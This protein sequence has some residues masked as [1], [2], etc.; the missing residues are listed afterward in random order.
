MAEPTSAVF[1]LTVTALQTWS[2]FEAMIKAVRNS[3]DD[4][5]HWTMMSTLI[6]NSCLLMKEKLER[7][8]IATLSPAQ[9]DFLESIEEFLRLFQADLS[10]LEMPDTDVFHGG[11]STF[12]D[13]AIAA[14]RLQLDQ[15][16]HLIKRLDRNIQM[17]Q[18]STSCLSLFEP[19][20]V[21]RVRD[22][23]NDLGTA[24]PGRSTDDDELKKWRQTTQNLLADTA[25]KYFCENPSPSD[26]QN[27]G[28]LPPSTH[29]KGSIRG[30]QYKFESAQNWAT[31]FFEADMPI[32]ALPYQ[33]QAIEFGEELR[34]QQPD[35]ALAMAER[36]DL[37]AKYVGIAIACQKH[38]QTAVASAIKRLDTL[39]T[40]VIAESEPHTSAKLC[41][42]QR[43]IAKMFADLNETDKTI[44]YFQHALDGYIHL[45]KDQ[46]HRKICETYN[47]V[48]EQFQRSRRYIDLDVFRAVMRDD[49][50]DDFV[51]GRDGL[52]RAVTWCTPRGFEVTIEDGLSFAQLVNEEGDTPLHVAAKDREMDM[53]VLVKLMTLE[54]FYEMK[55]MNGDTP[56]LVAVSNSNVKVLKE[57]LTRPYLVLVRDTNRQTP[58]HRCR[59]KETLRIVLQ[60]IETARTLP[61][62]PDLEDIDIDTK[63]GYGQTALH[64]FCYQLQAD[65]V[66]IL[67]EQGADVNAFCSGDRTPLM[68]ALRQGQSEAELHRIIKVLICKGTHTIGTDRYGQNDLEKAL[69][70]RGYNKKKIHRLTVVDSESSAMSSKSSGRASTNFSEK[71]GR[72]PAWMSVS[73]VA[74]TEP[75]TDS[76]YAS[77]GK[78][79][80]PTSV[81]D[82]TSRQQLAKFDPHLPHSRDEDDAATVYSVAAS[83]PENDMETYKSELSDAIIKALRPHVSDAE[84]L[85]S[86]TS[87]LPL[88]LQSFAL[89]LGCPG[90]GKA[91]REVMYF[92]HKYRNEITKRFDD[93]VR[94]EKDEDDSKPLD[95]EQDKA[96]VGWNVPH[97]LQEVSQSEVTEQDMPHIHEGIYLKSAEEEEDYLSL[98]DKRGYRD[99]I[100]KSVAYS[101][102]KDALVKTLAMALV[103]GEDGPSLTPKF[104]LA[105]RELDDRSLVTCHFG[106]SQLQVEVEGTADSIATVAEQII[107]LGASLRRSCTESGLATCRPRIRRSGPAGAGASTN[108]DIEFTIEEHRPNPREPGTGQC[109]HEMFRNPVVVG[110]YP[111][112]RRTQYGSGL[113]M[114]LN[115]MAGLTGCPRV[116]QYL[117]HHFL[118]GF[119]TAL[120]PTGMMKDAILWH[121]YYT[122]DGSRLPYPDMDSMDKINVGFEG[123]SQG[124]H[125]VGWCSKAQ[126]FT[127]A[128]GMNYAI[129]PSLLDR[130]GR[131]FA[132]EKI[133]FSVGQI[134]TG[135]CQFAIGRKDAHVRI[136]HNSYRAKLAWLEQKYVTLWD[137][138]EERGWLVNG[139]SALLHLLRTSLEYSKGDKFKSEFLFQEKKFEESSRPFTLDSAR[140]VLLSETNKKLK[141]YTNE[142]HSYTETKDLPSGEIETVTKTVTSWTTIKDRIE[143]LYETVEKLIDHNAMSQ[144]GIDV[145]TRPHDHLN[146]WDFTDIATDRDP[147]HLRKAKLPLD[148]MTWVEFT[149]AIPA[150]TLFGKGFGDMIRALPQE[151]G[152]CQ[153][154]GT[155]PK[156]RHLLCVSVADLRAIIKQIVGDQVTNPITVAPGIVWK[157]PFSDIQNV[158]K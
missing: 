103:D 99:A 49:L 41:E 85:E 46:Y 64:L 120:V 77:V 73:S 154:W 3:P 61:S 28:L 8:P 147:F 68:L 116:N 84:Q 146:G 141:L 97:W 111:I 158:P 129:K 31:R 135:G 19:G 75:Q 58:I 26:V 80:E 60:A 152:G 20:P 143:E 125:I 100:F 45:G 156:S 108:F 121:L 119:A 27:E 157:N 110:G 9:K 74:R 96:P 107:W 115:V 2:V 133:S 124:R 30:L 118:K 50:G 33:L 132:L 38:D 155:V 92:V 117:G 47:M 53:S 14:F 90:S 153:A 62:R 148:M 138:D 91:E 59:D 140:D 70:R 44:D 79:T 22:V 83:V 63:D 16:G 21:D 137:V 4:I 40:T 35:Y 126:F 32:L 123:L 142:H 81:G 76:G 10:K 24:F 55:D 114:P 57:L 151:T 11:D 5:R 52:A 43:R 102:L 12:K 139:N 6:I 131:E 106:H 36:T 56:L 95:V 69:S 88:L 130:P 65:L 51:Q 66:K 67:V 145:K 113:E 23:L 144:K 7:W 72:W 71:K 109:W 39:G 98:L 112:P 122:A 18:V 87:H 89:R 13:R 1:A 25:I 134:V 29:R 104:F 78:D 42:E 101:W 136:T 54:R 93:A 15:D 128:A 37:A 34:E 127:G 94:K 82:S 105:P 48:V 86:V 17:F 149:K 150:I